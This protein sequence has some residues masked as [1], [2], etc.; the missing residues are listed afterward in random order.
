[1]K[2]VLSV[3]LSASLFLGLGT[4]AVA[5]VKSINT[6]KAY[7][8]IEETNKEI[9]EEINRGVEEAKKLQAEYLSDVRKLEKGKGNIELSSKLNDAKIEEIKS[10][11]ET[12]S[13]KK[14]EKNNKVQLT[15]K[16]VNKVT[17]LF[18]FEDIYFVDDQSSVY[19]EIF[20]NVLSNEHQE[21]TVN[22]YIE[23]GE[24][25]SEVSNATLEMSQE[26]I[27]EVSS[28]VEAECFWVDVQFADLEV[29]IDP[30]HIVG[31]N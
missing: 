31:D 21:L 6:L 30:I 18:G 3:L 17:E 8:L 15:K 5:E 25:I 23:L 13:N 4:S 29:L 10:F 24:I 2:K 20:N 9:A 27:E 1:M 28:V 22:Y 26:T 7:E 19:N 12:L 14:V 16:E 11:L